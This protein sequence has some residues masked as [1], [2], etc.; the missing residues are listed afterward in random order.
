MEEKLYDS[1]QYL[2]KL[3]PEYLDQ[4]FESARWI[5]EQD[6]ERALEVRTRSP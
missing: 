2:R 3:G 6:S 1:I 4:V 5:I